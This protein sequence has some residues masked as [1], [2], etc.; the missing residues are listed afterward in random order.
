MAEMS[1]MQEH[2]STMAQKIGLKANR[3]R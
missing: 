1:K 2:F 3:S